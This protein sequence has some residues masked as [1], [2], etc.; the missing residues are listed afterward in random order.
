MPAIADHID[1][2]AL[3]SLSGTFPVAEAEELR[4]DANR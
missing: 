3:I 4:R 1:R 2:E